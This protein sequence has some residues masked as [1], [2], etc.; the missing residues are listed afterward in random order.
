[1]K[2]VRQIRTMTT[3]VAFNAMYKAIGFSNNAAT[4]LTKTEVVDFMPNLSCITSA[5]ASKICNYA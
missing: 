3:K 5:L 4:E 1:M 2:N